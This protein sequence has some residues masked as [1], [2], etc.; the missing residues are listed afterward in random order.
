[1]SVSPRRGWGCICQGRSAKWVTGLGRCR[2]GNRKTPQLH[3]TQGSFHPTS[4]DQLL[5]P[6]PTPLPGTR[7]GLQLPISG[8]TEAVNEAGVYLMPAG[9]ELKPLDITVPLPCKECTWH[10]H[11]EAGA[12]TTPLDHSW[13]LGF[14]PSPLATDFPSSTGPRPMLPSPSHG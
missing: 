11:A 8:E 3:S 5:P 13:H 6:L 1:M 4:T 2:E 12:L 7:M 14:G 9:A 10:F